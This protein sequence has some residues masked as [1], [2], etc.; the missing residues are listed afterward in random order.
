MSF[1]IKLFDFYSKFFEW[2]KES[3]KKRSPFANE[4]L[5]FS[6]WKKKVEKL[7]EHD[8]SEL[9]KT[10]MKKKLVLE[11]KD[12][13]IAFFICDKNKKLQQLRRAGMEASFSP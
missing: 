2:Y 13:S 7:K 1:T 12:E 10:W 3:E 5:G 9:H 6:N 8:A 4:T 11:G